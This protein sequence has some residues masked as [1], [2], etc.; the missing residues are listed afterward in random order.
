MA[1]DRVACGATT[2]ANIPGIG[3]RTF[4]FFWGGGLGLL[5]YRR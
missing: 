2:D 1:L 3:A 5:H 4:F